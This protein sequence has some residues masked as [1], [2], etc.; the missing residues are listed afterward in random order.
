MASQDLSDI[1]TEDLYKAAAVVEG[2]VSV[3]VSIDQ[4]IEDPYYLGQIYGDG[5]V[6]PYWVERLRQIYPNPLYSP[7]QECLSGDTE[8]DLLDGST[9]T[10]KQLYEEYR[11][12]S[13]W[14][15]GFNPN[16]K[17]WEPCKAHS[18]AVTG[19][20]PVYKVTLDNGKSFKASAEHPVLGKDNRWYRTDALK[21]GQSLM[22]YNLTYDEGYAYVWDNRA[23][24]NVKRC[25]LVQNWKN[26]IPPGYHVHHKNQVRS[27]DT[28]SNV[29]LLSP[30]GHLRLHNLLLQRA[31]KDPVKAKELSEK[32][33]K[34]QHAARDADPEKYSKQRSRNIRKALAHRTPEVWERMHEGHRKWVNSPEGKAASSKVMHAFNVA[35]KDDPAWRAELSRRGK[36]GTLKRWENATAE[37]RERTSARLRA[38]NADPDFMAKAIAN[39]KA[40]HLNRLLKKLNQIENLKAIS[41]KSLNISIQKSI[42]RHFGCMTGTGEHI[43][44]AALLRVWPEVVERALN[45]N[46]RIVSIEL[47]PAETVYNFEVDGLHNFPLACGIIV[48]NC[49]ISGAIGIGKTTLSIIGVLYDLYHIL[50]LKD[51]HRKY[52]LIPTTPIVI[53]LITA[54]MDLAGAVMANQLL[55]AIGASPFFLEHLLPRKGEKIDEDMFPHHIGITFGSRGS[56]NLGKAV[57]GAIIDEANFQ[58]KVADQALQN[59]NT[60]KRRM[61][62]RFMTKGGL[63]PC[64]LWI[65]SSRHE[66]ASFLEN[67][68]D[69]KRG[70]PGIMVFEPSIWEVQAHKGIYCGKTFPVFTGS[71]MEQPRILTRDEEVEAYAGYVIHVPIE[72][73]EQFED[74]L[75]HALQDLAG[76]ATRNGVNLIYNVEKLKAALCLENCMSTDEPYLTLTGSDSLMDFYKTPL[77]PG[78]YYAHM[79][80][81]KNGDR[82]GFAMSRV[83]EQICIT[84]RSAID[85]TERSMLS[86]LI[87][88][89]LAFGVKAL[90]GSQIP[91]FKLREFLC[92]LRS[93]G[94]TIAYVSCDGYN[95]V[96]MLQLLTKLGFKN[97]YESVDRTKDAYLKLAENVVL[98]LHKMPKSRV[99]ENELL[100]LQNLPNKVDHP[101][102]ILVN[103]VAV[104]GGKDIADACSASAFCAIRE[105]LTLSQASM[106]RQAQQAPKSMTMR[107]RQEYVLEYLKLGQ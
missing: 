80:A 38:L 68:I 35:H 69:Q 22:P 100:N 5:G 51:P 96:D 104:K 2:Y 84:K 105:S 60:I 29:M 50:L 48:H 77:P 23:Q 34:G 7:A 92:D 21:V 54:T 95:T 107:E 11:G 64:R 49:L 67:H 89:P 45:Y 55:D 43:D 73:R 16:T 61:Q 3:P 72:Y 99:L 31:W 52:K 83:V 88:T 17:S 81:A 40:A 18:V 10:M 101:R 13:F 63:L 57:I 46:H 6:Y 20:K 8:V 42:A 71:P 98:G 76:V 28:P 93:T 62:S 32:M 82:F 87:E 90:P 97:G 36:V 15:L 106:I 102:T 75:P 39:G 24:K 44:N 47:L 19:F 103:G 86:P 74:D 30:G 26:P 14:V 12:K 85:G 53:S 78:A 56:H 9:K 4:F 41:P 91:F 66:S 27:D 94:V 37:D 79:D 58:D 59:Y 70:R 1:S 25:R 65:A 33:S